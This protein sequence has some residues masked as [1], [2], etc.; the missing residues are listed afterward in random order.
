MN[1]VCY[2]LG[3]LLVGKWFVRWAA[4]WRPSKD[5]EVLDIEHGAGSKKV[6][7]PVWLL[8]A[9]TVLLLGYCLTSALN[10]RA[11]Y[12]PEGRLFEYH[13][14]LMWLPHSYDSASTWPAFEEHMALATLFWAARDWVLGGMGTGM[15]GGEEGALELSDWKRGVL[16]PGRLRGLLWLISINATLIALEGILQRSLG[17][18]KLLWLV[19]PFY[20]KEPDRQFGP[21]AYRSNA[22][23][24]LGLAWPVALG[25]W[26]V[27]RHGSTRRRWARAAANFLLP[28][29]LLMAVA[30]LISLSRAGAGITCA[31]GVIAGAILV[32]ARH[33][34]HRLAGL[35]MAPFLGMI[36]LAGWYI[37]WNSLSQRLKT[38]QTDFDSTRY[39]AW[40]TSLKMASDFPVFGTGPGTFKTMYGLYRT[41]PEQEWEAYL[42]NDWLETVITFGWVGFAVILCGL[43]LAP[44]CW[45]AGAGAIPAHRVLIGF[46]CLSLGGCLVYAVVDFP[47]QIYSVVSLFV[48]ICCVLSC[49]T[50]TA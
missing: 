29:I 36:I 45:F 49:L 34:R 31:A 27:L 14:C 21:Y 10:A 11:T 12:A 2:A 6:R 15:A 38:T 32:G 25:F 9:S 43:I 30:A 3:G 35:A 47:F 50:R 18:N 33:R 39:L 40:R 19:E 48:L 44:I 1:C 7:W 8:A 4:D 42:H 37:G 20:N 13:T 16:L 24:Y 41:T 22:V 17:T 5:L 28:C 23:Q 26:W 46:L